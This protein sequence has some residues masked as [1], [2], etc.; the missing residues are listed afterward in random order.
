MCSPVTSAG[1][2]ATLVLMKL[3]T[4][5]QGVPTL[6]GAALIVPAVTVGNV[7]QLATDLLITTSKATLVGTL[8]DPT[9]LSVAGAR[10]FQHAP[11]L[12]LSLQLF[13][14]PG[15]RL[16]LLQQRA[17]PAP[18]LQQRFAQS[19]AAWAQEAGFAKVRTVPL[20]VEHRLTNQP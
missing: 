18:G 7:G 20:H 3:Y 1:S 9:L 10:A 19:L 5:V 17:P 15:G 11:G 4:G 12:A 6:Q 2:C 8:A 14:L 16:Y 13:A